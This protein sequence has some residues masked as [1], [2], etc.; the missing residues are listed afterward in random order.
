MMFA[1]IPGNGVSKYGDQH[2]WPGICLM[3]FIAICVFVAVILRK[4]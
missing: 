2:P 3:A 1:H 4:K